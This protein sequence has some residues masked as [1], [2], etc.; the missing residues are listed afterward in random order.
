M[1]DLWI[2]TFVFE[3]NRLVHSLRLLAY[4]GD[5]FTSEESVRCAFAVVAV[6][7]GDPK[8][9]PAHERNLDEWNRV[10]GLLASAEPTAW[11]TAATE[12][13]I[14]EVAAEVKRE[15]RRTQL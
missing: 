2:P 12:A 13:R 5:T 4:P 15:P 6:R 14:E 3:E 8:A 7:R 10:V 1:A 11:V 9:P